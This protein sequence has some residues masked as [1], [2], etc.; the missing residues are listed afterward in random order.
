[1]YKAQQRQFEIENFSVSVVKIFQISRVKIDAAL[2]PPSSYSTNVRQKQA[3]CFICV[4]IRLPLLLLL[5]HASTVAPTTTTIINSHQYH[6]R[7]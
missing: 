3:G 1:M 2:L 5:H 6:I 7:I 4:A